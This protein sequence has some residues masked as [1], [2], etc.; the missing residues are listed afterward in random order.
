MAH[1]ELRTAPEEPE[2]AVP[3]APVQSSVNNTG[4]GSRI[5]Q[6]ITLLAPALLTGWLT[7][8]FGSTERK[9]TAT[10]D[11]QTQRLDS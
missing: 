4:E 6:L 2:P 8:S 10:M 3:V 5:W 11:S 1:G 7:F 9:I